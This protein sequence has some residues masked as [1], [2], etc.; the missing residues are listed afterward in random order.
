MS[1]ESQPESGQMPTKRASLTSSTRAPQT[2]RH[3]ARQLEGLLAGIVASCDRMLSTM[4]ATSAQRLDAKAIRDAAERSADLARR[5]RGTETPRETAS[6]EAKAA[7]RGLPT[8]LL[9]DDEDV[10]RRLLRGV[11]RREGFQV[12]EA[13]GANEARA[14]SDSHP[15]PIELLIT[16]LVMPGVGGR[17]L[18]EGLVKRRPEMRVI[19]V[20][21]FVDEGFVRQG[22]LAGSVF[23]QKPFAPSTLTRQVRELLATRRAR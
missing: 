23:L 19:Y 15:G 18:A 17:E 12:L 16:D 8:I 9:V 21:G 20:S 3:L 1:S 14:L 10:V 7:R 11:L 2:T 4:P 22:A 13:N 5:L 6:D